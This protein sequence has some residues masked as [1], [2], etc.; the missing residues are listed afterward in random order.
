MVDVSVLIL[1]VFGAG[2]TIN[3]IF[4]LVFL[5]LDFFFPP[6][7]SA[8]LPSEIE[9]LVDLFFDDGKVRK[10]LNAL[11]VIFEVVDKIF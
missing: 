8:F 4:I 1:E 11:E 5:L 10:G 2:L 9:V 7:E 3:E 6:T